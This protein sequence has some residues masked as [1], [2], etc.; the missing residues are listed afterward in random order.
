MKLNLGCGEVKHDGYINVDKYDIFEPDVVQDLEKFPWA[1]EDNSVD[2]IIMHHV[3]EHLGQTTEEYMN[4]LA[5]LHRIYVN[6]ML[7]LKFLFRIHIIILLSAIQH[8]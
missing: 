1:F 7:Q 3:L 6:Q 4:I 5:E 2:E 8:T